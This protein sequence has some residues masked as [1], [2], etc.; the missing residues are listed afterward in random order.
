M[1]LEDN[2]IEDDSWKW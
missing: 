2:I 1:I